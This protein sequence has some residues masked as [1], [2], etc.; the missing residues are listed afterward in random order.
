MSGST[1]YTATFRD[2]A[3]ALGFAFDGPNPL[4]AQ[5][6]NSRGPNKDSLYE[7]Y[8]STEEVGTITGLVPLYD[9]LQRLFRDTIT[10]SGGNNDAIR[11]S[12]I[13]LLYHAHLCA[14]SSDEYTDFWIDIMDFIFNEMHAAWLGWV[15]LPY[16]P[17]IMLLIK[18]VVQDMDLPGNV[19]HKVKRPYIKRKGD[20][21]AT[22]LPPLL[23]RTPLR[24]MLA[25]IHHLML[26]LL[27]P[28]M[29]LGNSSNSHG[30]RRTSCT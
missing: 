29:P 21:A 2:F 23:A 7:L 11:T 14:S 15:T 22:P 25:P 13:D 4:G 9:Q 30:F 8:T 12:L 18:H 28:R 24:G 6:F 17:Y 26:S 27:L 16:D 20:G 1:Q 3:D 5:F 19:D 10:P